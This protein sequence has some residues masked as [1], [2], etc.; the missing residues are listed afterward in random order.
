MR[1]QRN[2]GD[3]GWVVLQSIGDDLRRQ[4]MSEL[5]KSVSAT[6]PMR[7]WRSKWKSAQL[8]D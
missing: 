7:R 6:A 8:N 5:R 3:N 4:V 1:Q 2:A